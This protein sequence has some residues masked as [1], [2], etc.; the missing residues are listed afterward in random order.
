MGLGGY[1]AALEVYDKQTNDYYECDLIVIC[2][3]GVFVTEL[4]HWTGRIQVAPRTWLVNGSQHRPE[5]PTSTTG[6]SSLCNV[7]QSCQ[8][9]FI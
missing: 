6:D 3:F 5:L 7:V 2:A 9:E 4:K 1:V 8:N